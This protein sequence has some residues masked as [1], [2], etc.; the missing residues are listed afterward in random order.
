[1]ALLTRVTRVVVIVLIGV[2]SERVACHRI[3]DRDGD[4]ESGEELLTMEY[5]SDHK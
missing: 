3:V 4:A 5:L 2:A 1:M